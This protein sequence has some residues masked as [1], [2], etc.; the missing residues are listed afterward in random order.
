MGGMFYEV[1]KYKDLEIAGVHKVRALDTENKKISFIGM[2]KR[3]ISE[4]L[5]QHIRY[6]KYNNQNTAFS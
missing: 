6:L 1:E 4:R 2:T 5:K 3:K